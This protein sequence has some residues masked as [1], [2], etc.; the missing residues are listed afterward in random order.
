MLKVENIILEPV[1]SEKAALATS[2][3]NTYTFKVGD[4]AN[5]TSVAQAIKQVY[6]KVDVVSVHILN[7]HPKAKRSRYRRGQQTLKSAYKKALV[8][9]KAG[10]NLEQAK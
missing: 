4:A 9:L 10:Q 5:K 3:T 1:V 6:P 2:T 8:T 7:V